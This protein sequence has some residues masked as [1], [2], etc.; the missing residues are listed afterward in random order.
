L[1]LA[2]IF[3]L[4]TVKGYNDASFKDWGTTGKFFYI[5]VFYN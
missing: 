2:A 5:E 3:G 4:L 1:L